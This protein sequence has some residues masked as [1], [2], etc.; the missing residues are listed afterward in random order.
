M[1]LSV[2]YR[3]RRFAEVVGQDVSKRIL[4]NSILMNR[5]PSA[6]LISGI[7]GTGKT[8]LARIYAK[9]LNCPTF[10]QT[11]D[12]CCACPSCL[13]VD[14]GGHL[15]I[16]ELDAAS[17]SG[18]D[19][20]RRLDQILD[21][22]ILHPYRVVILD[23]A[24][25]MSK[26]AQA[27]L[28]K[29][30]E[31]PPKNTVFIL[32][33]TDPQRL[34]DTIRSRCLSMPLRPLTDAEVAWNVR[35]LL[36][37][38]GIPFTE[39]FVQTLSRLGGGSL[40]DV[41][42]ILDSLIMAAGSGPLDI[43]LLQESVGV[44]SSQEYGELADVLDQKNLKL[45]M[46]EIRRWYEEGRD[47]PHLFEDGIP[48][49][50]RD[51]LVFLTGSWSPTTPFL[52]GLSFDSLSGNLSLSIPEVREMIREWEVTMGFMKTTTHPQVVWEMFAVK[53]CRGA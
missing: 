44:I 4:V 3:P 8:T 23:E 10:P 32:V 40:R 27:A 41:Q 49:L 43:G 20:V 28:L 9:A 51:F 30:I 24:H 21:Q 15:S 22:V 25:M 11:G 47:L 1:Q 29:T 42:Q 6:M 38:D 7:R 31:E 13:D 34:E 14:S 19:D 17:N 2:K 26:S 12:V 46:E 52:S 50:L 16:L 39:E 35:G 18:V 5:V 45:F 33:T 36:T 37:A 48:V 53:V